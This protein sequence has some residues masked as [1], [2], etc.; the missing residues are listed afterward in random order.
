MG[1]SITSRIAAAAVV[2]AAVVVVATGCGGSPPPVAST[3][4]ETSQSAK[5]FQ[6]HL[7]GLGYWTRRMQ[8][9]SLGVV[10]GVTTASDFAEDVDTVKGVLEYMEL[11]VPGKPALNAKRTALLAQ[12]AVV[13]ANANAMLAAARA[14][15]VAA[16]DD[17]SLPLLRSADKLVT[18]TGWK[19]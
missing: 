3:T 14:G 7:D 16:I 17:A 1:P 5:D 2:M 19:G 9:N 11:P 10:S 8:V 13:V 4:V 6:A 15:K 18:M 12:G